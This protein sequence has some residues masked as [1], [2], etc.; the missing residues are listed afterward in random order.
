MELRTITVDQQLSQVSEYLTRN[1]KQESIVEERVAEIIKTVKEQGDRAVFQ[2]TLLFDGVDLSKTGLLVSQDELDQAYNE[3]NKEFVSALRTAKKRIEA[4]HQ[5]QLKQSWF[6]AEDNGTILGQLLRPLERVGLYTPGGR[7]VYPSSVLMTA[8]PASLAGVKELILCTPPDRQGRVNPQL[9]VAARETGV[10]KV[11]RCGG[12]QA[13]AALAWGTET[14]PSVDKIVGPGNTYVAT[15]K[16]QLY[17]QV[18]IDSVAGPSEVVIISDSTARPQWIAADLIAQA[19]HDPEATAILITSEEGL[20]PQLFACLSQQLEEFER[21]NI[22]EQSLRD[23]GTVFLV[24]NLDEAAQVSNLIA[25]EHLELMVNDPWSLLSKINS[26]GAI[27]LGEFSP[28]AL[29]DYSAG[30]NHVLPTNGTA[31]FFSALSVDHFI[32]KINLAAVSPEGLDSF[33]GSTIQLA[34]SEGLPGHARA[35]E[36]RLSALEKEGKLFG[37]NS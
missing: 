29:G 7:A 11:Y 27:F 6:M 5:K 19:E 9:L 20:L 18:D 15:A 1:F 22:V 2:Y 12:A 26:A 35:V 23:K 4:F 34:N 3:V 21:K 8:I 28:V 25:P 16:K 13:V 14:I 10:T 33:G 37:Q 31:R 36:M 32:K 30:T 24:E 17:G